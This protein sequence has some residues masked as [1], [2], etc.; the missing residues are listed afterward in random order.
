MLPWFGGLSLSKHA[1][2]LGRNRRIASL[3]QGLSNRPLLQQMEVLLHL[4]PLD[5]LTMAK[6]RMTLYRLRIL[7]QPSVPKTVPGLLTIWKNVGDPLFDTQ[8]DY[9]IP[10]YRFTNISG[11]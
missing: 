6:A 8:L 11:S 4:T 2:H 3:L 1:R 9:T 7:K 10:I 5:L